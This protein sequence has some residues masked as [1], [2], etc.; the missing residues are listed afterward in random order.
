MHVQL[1]P[2]PVEHGTLLVLGDNRNASLDAHLWGA[3]HHHRI[4][5]GAEPQTM[6]ELPNQ[7]SILRL[8]AWLHRFRGDPARFHHAPAQGDGHHHHKQEPLQLL[9]PCVALFHHWAI[10]EHNRDAPPGP[11]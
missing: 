7:N 5:A 4:A 8:Q 3:E 6:P 10:G 2:L 1:G 9:A 11:R